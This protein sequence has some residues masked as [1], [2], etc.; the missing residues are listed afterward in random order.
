MSL[1]ELGN[2]VTLWTVSY[3]KNIVNNNNRGFDLK[4]YMDI[5]S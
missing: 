3:M 1:T 5:L 4:N 2:V